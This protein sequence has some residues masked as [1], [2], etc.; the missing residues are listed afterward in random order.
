M[1]RWIP[2]PHI[3]TR[4][5]SNSI[6]LARKLLSSNSP[7]PAGSAWWWTDWHVAYQYFLSISIIHNWSDHFIKYP[8]EYPRTLK[9]QCRN[10]KIPLPHSHLT[11]SRHDCVPYDFSR[12]RLKP[13]PK[14][15]STSSDMLP[16]AQCSLIFLIKQMNI[17]SC[18][19]LGNHLSVG[20]SI[21]VVCTSVSRSRSSVSQRLCLTAFDFR[22]LLP[23]RVHRW[24]PEWESAVN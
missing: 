24:W 11:P 4:I 15:N 3:Y 13:R 16:L 14:P 20:T 5:V 8:C 18:A 23:A 21:R 12:L 6:K 17:T 7:Q 2:N 22:A 1:H 19:V 9:R 10:G